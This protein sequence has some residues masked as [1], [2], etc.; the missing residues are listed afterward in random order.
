MDI[1]GRVEVDWRRIGVRPPGQ[2][3]RSIDESSVPE[4]ARKETEPVLCRSLMLLALLL[5]IGCSVDQP[6]GSEGGEGAATVGAEK[7]PDWRDQNKSIQDTARIMD[8][9]K[10]NTEAVERAIASGDQAATEQLVGKL[11]NIGGKLVEQQEAS[12]KLSNQS[13][14]ITVIAYFHDPSLNE[15]YPASEVLGATAMGLLKSVD[16]AGKSVVV[17][18]ADMMVMSGSPEMLEQLEKLA[19]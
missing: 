15:Q 4:L 8:E 10:R 14:G 11:V 3:S 9:A 6:A 12:W 5:A 17:D 7:K 19:Q 1:A 16:V 2:L 13:N 18:D